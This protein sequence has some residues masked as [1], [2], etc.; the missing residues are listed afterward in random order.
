MNIL[1]TGGCGFIGSHIAEKL[2]SED[3]KVTIID[4]LSTGRLDNIDHL[5]GDNL[6]VVIEDISNYDKIQKYFK[7]IDIVYH[8]AALADIV[9]SIENPIQ[10]HNSNVNGTLS[11]LEC[12][13]KYKIKRFIYAAS[14]SC[15]GIP[16]DYPTNELAEIKPQYPYAT[17]KYLGETYVMNWGI[18][19]GLPVTSLRFFN[20]YGTRSRTSGTYGAVFGVFL[21]QK[22]NNKPFTVV[23]NG[24]QTRD[25]TYVTDVADACI[26]ASK[27]EVAIGKVYNVGSG[28][29]YSI[30]ELTSLLG[31]KKS[32]IPKRPGEP[33]CTFADITKIKSEL[34]WEP[35]VS[36][37]DGVEIILRNIDYWKDAPVWEPNSIKEAT[38]LWFKYLK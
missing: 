15:Y 26:E 35:K 12:S 32:Y 13:R 25:F 18:V 6:N 17:S 8:I 5:V 10:Y 27:H 29:T 7:S 24:N 22:L 37:K 34:G 23:G 1:I 14:S 3:H 9:P 33:D 20:V 2:L 21:A 11:V 19:Y 16:T 4:N 38:K 36:L 30:N 28:N 31:G